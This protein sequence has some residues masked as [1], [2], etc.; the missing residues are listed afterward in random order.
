MAPLTLAD[1]LVLL[2]YDDTGVNRLG[3]P[4]LDYGLSGAV[5]LELALAGR[6]EVADD[7]LAVTDPTPVGRPVLDDALARVAADGKRR[8]PKDWISRLA[9]GLPDRVLSGL[10]DTGVLRRDS[11]RVLL[12]FPRTRYPSP[13]GA[14]PTAETAARQRMLDALLADGP[15][16]ARTAALLGLTR[17]VGLDRKL[18]R[19]LPK[20]RLKARTTEIA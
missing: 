18:F 2:A 1:E 7:R 9:K 5:L 15:V 10:V 17:A 3:R 6:V 13:T 11:D 16:E 4:H 14:E 20:E 19:E 12:V 8:R